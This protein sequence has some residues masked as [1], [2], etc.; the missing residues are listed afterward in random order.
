MGIAFSAPPGIVLAETF[1]RGVARGFPA[2]F[3]VQLGALIG[4]TVYCLLALAGVA[5]LVQ[6]P[7]TQRVLGVL[8]VV[9]LLYLAVSGIFAELRA[10]KPDQ[11]ATVESSTP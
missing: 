2:A 11:A 3:S 10:V 5:V 9:F 7:I 6:N 1:R 4:D 8:S